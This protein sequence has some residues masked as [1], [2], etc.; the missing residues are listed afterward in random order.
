MFTAY[1]QLEVSHTHHKRFVLPTTNYV[2][3]CLLRLGFYAAEH[4]RQGTHKSEILT[5]MEY[6][7]PYLVTYCY[8]LQFMQTS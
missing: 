5:R 3:R 6:K 7:Y 4:G 2:L 1:I 8:Y